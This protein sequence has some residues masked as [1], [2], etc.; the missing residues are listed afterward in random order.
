MASANYE[1]KQKLMV[2]ISDQQM[3]ALISY[4]NDNG[5]TR[6]QLIR[7]LL[8]PIFSGVMPS[9]EELIND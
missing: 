4:C 5:I 7:Q 2:E 6:T 8:K 9:W 1:G 3:K